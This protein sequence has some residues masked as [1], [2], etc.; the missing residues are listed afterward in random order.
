LSTPGVKGNF[1]EH[2]S[3]DVYG[4]YGTTNFENSYFN[5]YSSTRIAKALQAVTDS[6]GN[7]VCRANVDTDP[8]NNDPLCVPWNIFVENGVTPEA[9]GYVSAPGFQNGDTKETVISGYVN[10]DLTDYGVKLPWANEGLAISVGAEYREE[11]SHLNNDVE[12]ATNDLTGLGGAVLDTSGHYYVKE[13]FIE[14]RMPLVSDAPWAKEASLD[15]GYRYSDYSLNFNTDTYK[16]GAD[17]MPIE[18][19]RFRGSFQRAVRAPNIQE[20]FRP[21]VVQLDG[22]T[23]PCAVDDP[24]APLPAD[25]PSLAECANTGVTPA[26]YGTIASNPA[27][28]YNGLTGGNPV[29]QP[30]K[31]DT[32]TFGFVLTPTRFTGFTMSVDYF[33]I[34]IDD[35]INGVGADLAVNTCLVSGNPQ[36]CNLVHRAPSGSLWLG[37]TGFVVDT[38]QNLGSLQTKGVDIDL[39][40][41][42]E[43]PRGLG[44]LV[45]NVMA[46]YVDELTTEPLPGFPKYDCAGLFGNVC[47]IPTSEWRHV[48]RL[49]W[50]TPWNLDVA[51]SWRFLSNVN[52]ENTVNNSNFN[53]G[54][55]TNTDKGIDAQNYYDLASQYQLD[56]R[57][58]HLTFRAGINNIL[59]AD[60]PL[61]GQDIA[62]PVYVN[63]N[64]Y[65]QAYDALGRYWFLSVSAK[66]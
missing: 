34:K 8:G 12:F 19:V 20:L 16:Y 17:W 38:N 30:E 32:Y 22:S 27:G 7:V 45:L 51:F 49:T 5:D 39:S 48:S 43:L 50:N 24:L 53:P 14:G 42:L 29:L 23:D 10:G 44:N 47:G 37:Q 33:D 57:F 4:Q 31:A 11:R 13:V 63:G 18:D 52:N 62:S 28:Q 59:D 41:T 60:P 25:F 61:F 46:T 56:T 26:Q 54:A 6:N 64:T 2:W 9:I 35:V 58:T 21:Q 15:A 55:F 36:F 1:D 66:L 40:N 65:P 3:Y